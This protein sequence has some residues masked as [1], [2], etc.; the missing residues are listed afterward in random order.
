MSKRYN[1][2]SHYAKHRRAEELHEG[3]AH[4]HDVAEQHGKQVHLTGREHSR[5][6]FAHSGVTQAH[7][8][9]TDTTGHGVASFGH[10]EIADL[11]YEL[12][13]GRGS[14]AGPP[15]EDWFCAVKELRSRAFGR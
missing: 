12:W 6:E 9:A 4:A 11:A 15:D 2:G 1:N 7:S 3:A 8:P 13:Q 5:Q 10:D 14:P